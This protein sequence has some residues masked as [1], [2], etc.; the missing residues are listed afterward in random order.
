[1]RNTKF[2]VLF[3]V[4]F[5]ILSFI[6]FL[7]E[8]NGTDSLKCE[9][10][11]IWDRS[12]TSEYG[13]G[14]GIDSLEDIYIAGYSD[15]IILVK[16]N[17]NGLELWNH[18][19]GGFAYEFCGGLTIDSSDNIYLAGSTE[20]FGA[21]NED[22][23]LIKYNRNG[24]KQWNITWG[25]IDFDRCYEVS[26]DDSGNLYLVGVTSSFG[27]GDGDI[28]LVKFDVN[29]LQQWNCTWGGT[30]HDAGRGLVVDS[31]GNIYVTGQSES[32]GAG[33]HDIVLIKY[34]NNGI[35]QWNTTWGGIAQDIGFAVVV[36]S[37]DNVYL[38]GITSGYPLESDVVLIKYNSN[39]IQLWN[40]TWGRMDQDY[41]EALVIDSSDNVY[42]VGESESY[43]TYDMFI[44]K[45][46]QNGT[47]QYNY[48]WGRADD[49]Y[50]YGVVVDSLDNLY[51]A[52]WTTSFG[53]G[54]STMI[55]LKFSPYIASTKIP[56]YNLF[57]IITTLGISTFFLRK[58]RIDKKVNY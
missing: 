4:F 49:D 12:Y 41:G 18:T 17:K 6:I 19:W 55:L 9:W 11:R 31:L 37:L 50:C 25:G 3:L 1:M 57:I 26:T 44:V 35:Q 52:G 38:T 54:D 56:S 30:S 21:G 23:I 10:Y 43:G 29:G 5:L 22:I 7:Q 34:D 42:V 47:Q 13:V 45:Y 20:S 51:V 15:D 33:D 48:L 32:F 40:R 39:G 16:Y 46:N 8:V 24:I 58:K 53:S 2:K 14:V 36:D 27:L 28:A